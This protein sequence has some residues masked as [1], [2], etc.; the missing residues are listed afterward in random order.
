MIKE[1]ENGHLQS[2]QRMNRTDEIGQMANTMDRFADS[3]QKEMVGPL[4]Q[5]AAGDLTFQVTP[6]DQQDEVR[7][8]IKM[9]GGDL[10]NIIA[11]IQAGAE[12]INAA[13]G[14]VSDSSQSLS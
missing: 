8:T 12:Q 14:Q 1:L 9:I 10:N 6:R 7:S 13:S 3:M 4:Q 2:R 11:Q 5:L